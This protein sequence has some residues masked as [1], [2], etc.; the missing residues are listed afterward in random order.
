MARGDEV[1]L[2]DVVEQELILP[3]RLAK[4]VVAF[5]RHGDGPGFLSQ[6]AQHGR[7]PESDVVPEHLRLHLRKLPGFGQHAC[8]KV[9]EC[10]GDPEFVAGG[11]A[12]AAGLALQKLPHEAAGALR[13][14]GEYSRALGG[15]GRG[16][17]RGHVG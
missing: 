8:I 1:G 14:L 7:L 12:L 17:R 16:L 11:D 6:H 10:P 3:V 13:H 2:L 4:T 9:H 5:G 15:I